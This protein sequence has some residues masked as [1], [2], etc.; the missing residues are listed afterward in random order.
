MTIAVRRLQEGDAEALARLND[1]LEAGGSE[2][3]VYPEDLTRNPSSDLELHPVHHALFVAADG[4]EVR[5]GAWL[6]EQYF[7]VDGVRHRVGWMKYP[8]CESLVDPQYAGVPASMFLQ[9]L[10]KQPNLMVIGMGGHYTPFA[11]L[12][13]GINWESTTIPML[14]RIVRPFRVLRRLRYARRRWWLRAAMEVAA[15]SGAGWVA[16]QLL[17]TGWTR[18]AGLS[19]ATATTEA[20]FAPWADAVWESCRGEYP[21][22]AVRDA[23]TLDH[24]NNRSVPNLHRIRVSRGGSDIGWVCAQILPARGTAPY[25]GDL[26][27]GIVTDALA[28]PADSRAVLA[29]GTRRLEELG[30]D[31]IITYLSHAAWIEAARRLRFLPGPST[32]TFYRSPG[33]ERLLVKGAVGERVYLTRS[34]G[35]GPAR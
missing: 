30:A 14:F 31:L 29:S 27:V 17:L 34:D 35:D 18:A 13:T 5:G 10:R 2:H 22:L 20:D 12:L 26:R 9:L 11:R 23:R 4:D 32:F 7:W 3:R 19:G 25:F 1:R 6:V 28:R 21:A 16:N 24:T 8:V 33:A 15:W